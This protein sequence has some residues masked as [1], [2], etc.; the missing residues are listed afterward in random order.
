MNHLSQTPGLYL[1]ICIEASV[2]FNCPNCSFLYD[3]GFTSNSIGVL[4][5]FPTWLTCPNCD[6]R[7]SL[8]KNQEQS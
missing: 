3:V 2:L 6:N 1:P 7:I 4:R 5:N 8:I